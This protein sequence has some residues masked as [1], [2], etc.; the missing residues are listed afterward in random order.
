MTRPDA[1]AP[2]FRRD[3]LWNYGALA[4]TVLVGAALNLVIGGIRGEQALGVFVQLYAIYVI[5]TQVAVLG[6]HDSVQQRVARIQGS[7]GAYR[8]FAPTEAGGHDEVRADAEPAS[9]SSQPTATDSSGGD[10]DAAIVA[11]AGLIVVAATATAAGLLVWFGRGAWALWVQSAMVGDGLA[12]VAPG[13]VVFALN[14]VFFAVLNGRGQLRR[15]ALLQILRA[16][17]VICAL[18]AV[19]ALDLPT[20]WVGAV[21]PL[22]E[23]ALLPCLWAATRLPWPVRGGSLG[24]QAARHLGF[25]G[26]STINSIILETHLRIDVLMLS[27]YVDDAAVG[28]YGFAALFAEGLY[29]V[30][31]VIRTVTFPTLVAAL[32][33]MEHDERRAETSAIARHRGAISLLLT[34]AAAALIY[35]VFT[36]LEALFPASLVANGTSILAVLLPAMALY[37]F[38]VPIDQILLQSGRPGRQ[39]ILVSTY[40][41][42]N[43]ALNA[44]MIPILGPIGAAVATALSLLS[45]ALLLLAATRIWLGYRLTILFYD[46]A[47]QR[48]RG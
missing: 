3:L 32:T 34:T 25:G 26:R 43:I 9:R 42:I 30:P 31:V 37:A 16:V 29:Q 39:S 21:L 17:L 2:G 10:G 45:A 20:P 36:Q 46:D 13:I 8:T 41:A 7:M 19:I 1:N 23:A 11:Q 35:G 27:F 18:G 28:A 44:L 5:L 15:Y 48:G 47:Q 24:A 6:V 12:F 38:V 22:A 4:V 33:R 14:K 40:V